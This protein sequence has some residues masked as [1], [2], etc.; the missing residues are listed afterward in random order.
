MWFEN[1]IDDRILLVRKILIEQKYKYCRYYNSGELVICYG[2][3]Q[4]LPGV[5]TSSI[6]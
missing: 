1:G 4:K 2:E 6:L 5:L 3:K